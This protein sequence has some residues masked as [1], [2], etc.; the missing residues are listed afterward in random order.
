MIK[1]IKKGCLEYE[2]QD[3]DEVL[4]SNVVQLKC[5]Q[6]IVVVLDFD[7]W[8]WTFY[9]ILHFSFWSRLKI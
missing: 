8:L 7:W 2:L 4:L 6:M 1:M 9:Y 5:I 3:N